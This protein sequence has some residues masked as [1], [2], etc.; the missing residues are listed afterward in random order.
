[1]IHNNNTIDCSSQKIF[2]KIQL[3]KGDLK[4]ATQNWN[5]LVNSKN[6]NKNY[7]IPASIEE[8]EKFDKYAP[9]LEISRRSWI[10]S[11]NAITAFNNCFNKIYEAPGLRKLVS[12]ETVYQVFKKELESEIF[13]RE[14]DSK[15]KREFIDVLEVIQEYINK[16]VD[17]FD[18]F[19]AIE[20]LKLEKIEKIKW[21]WVEN[22]SYISEDQVRDSSYGGENESTT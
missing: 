9:E 15:N 18:I 17:C 19:F 5:T 8:Y 21:V 22:R 20:G 12:Y 4:T 16:E 1:M 14:E 3:S 10:L 13:Q 2:M 6:K 7:Y 11:E